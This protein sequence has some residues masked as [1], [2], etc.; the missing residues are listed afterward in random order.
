[1]LILALALFSIPV[2]A[3]GGPVSEPAMR[4]GFFVSERD[5]PKE[6]RKIGAEGTS[7]V[8]VRIGANGRAAACAIAASSG[9][10]I[11]DVKTCAIISERARFDPARD[12]SGTKVE[13]DFD[14]TIA[15]RISGGCPTPQSTA[16]CV[17]LG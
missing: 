11:L 16:I 8:R 1:M 9:V 6:A 17:R 5:Y 2:Q 7:V 15:W 10:E 13:A 14:F 4:P 12:A 3:A